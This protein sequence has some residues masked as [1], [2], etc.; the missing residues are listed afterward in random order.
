MNLTAFNIQPHS[1]KYTFIFKH[2]LCT[3]FLPVRAKHVASTGR[4]ARIAA[5]SMVLL[6]ILCWLLGQLGVLAIHRVLLSERILSL[7]Y[8][9]NY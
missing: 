5:A 9:M 2:A 6:A 8:I 3:I 7:I 1:S 4:L